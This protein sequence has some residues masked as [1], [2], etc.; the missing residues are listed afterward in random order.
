MTIPQAI[1]QWLYKNPS[2]EIDERIDT[3]ILDSQAIAYALSKNPTNTKEVFVDGS[4][5]RTEYYTFFARQNS[6][7]ETERIDNDKFLEDLE[8]WIFERNFEGDLPVLDNKRY[9]DSVEIS[10][11]YYLFENDENESV[12]SLT[13]Q[14]TYRKEI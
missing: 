3:E 10:Q 5:L 4:E 11:G 2:I 6:Q 7:L 12:Y 14:I 1:K 13:I 8:N 9:C